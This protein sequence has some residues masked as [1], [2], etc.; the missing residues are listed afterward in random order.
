VVEGGD[1]AARGGRDAHGHGDAGEPDGPEGLDHA[2][3]LDHRHVGQQRESGE[4]RPAEDLGR[5]VERELALQDPG[6]RP[7]DRGERHVELAPP[8]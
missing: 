4:D 7:R 1:E 5:R 2:A 6:G 8:L 3:T